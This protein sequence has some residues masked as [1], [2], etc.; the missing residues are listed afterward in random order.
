MQW[1]GDVQWL[2]EL[3]AHLNRTVAQ[4]V[5]PSIFLQTSSTTRLITRQSERACPPGSWC[6]AGTEVRCAMASCSSSL[7]TAHCSSL[8]HPLLAIA[9]ASPC[10]THHALTIS[11][12]A[13]QVRCPSSTYNP[14]TGASNGTACLPCP[15]HRTTLT[16][17]ASSVEDCV[18]DNSR[19]RFKIP[20]EIG[21]GCG[22]KQGRYYSEALQASIACL[23]LTT[24][25]LLFTIMWRCR[26]A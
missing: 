19:Q 8:I 26:R 23:L 6:S 17:G 4:A 14:T 5:A 3:S 7:L 13:C 10:T 15:L 21:G 16:T 25:Y 18:C 12:L 24:Y 22:C 20:T 1:L 9:H 2:A 11:H